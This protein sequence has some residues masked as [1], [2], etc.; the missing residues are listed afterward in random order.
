MVLRKG[1]LITK[2]R[3]LPTTELLP[4]TRDFLRALIPELSKELLKGGMR[5]KEARWREG[6][7]RSG[8]GGPSRVWG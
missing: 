2:R 7:T 1:V 5:L 4:P 6:R 8:P 3:M